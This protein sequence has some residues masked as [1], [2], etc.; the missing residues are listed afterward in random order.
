MRS[1]RDNVGRPSGRYRDTVGPEVEVEVEVEEEVEEEAEAR[2]SFFFSLLPSQKLGRKLNPSQQSRDVDMDEN[3]NRQ[4][5]R[6]P[7]FGQD[8][9]SLE[10]RDERLR[11]RAEEREAERKR[12]ERYGK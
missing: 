2:L 10:E 4:T 3:T 11:L 8:E 5:V 9:E 1:C 12:L 6:P 7:G